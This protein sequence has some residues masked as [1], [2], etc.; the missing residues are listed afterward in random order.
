[1]R[2]IRSIAILA[3]LAAAAM[4]AGNCRGAEQRQAKLI[5][6]L[7]SPAAPAE[8]AIACKQLAI[9]G[10]QDA[11]PALAALLPDVQLS[12]WARIALEAIPGPAADAALR[13]ALGKVHGGLLLG[14]INSLGVRRDVKAVG[15]LIPR[16]NDADVEV[17]SA[18]AVAL[19]RIGGDVAT[20]A[21]AASLATSSAKTRAAVAEGCI[22]CAERSLAE[23]KP[24]EAVALYDAVRKADVSPQQVREAVRGLI[25]ARGAAGVPL[26][27]EQLQSADKASFALGLRVARELPGREVTDALLAEMSKAKPARQGLLIL[28]LADRGDAAALPAVLQMA[29]S[30]P[31]Q[32]RSVAIRVLRRLGNATCVPVLLDA[33]LDANEDVSQTAMT[34]LADM[35]GA[36]VDNDL[37]SRLLQAEGKM[38][39]ILIELAGRRPIATA[40]PTLLKA[41]GE[42]DGQVRAAALAALGATIEFRDLPLLIARVANP[43]DA[44]DDAAAA[45]A[46]GAACQRMPDREACAAKLVAAMSGAAAP[47]KCRLLEIL[48]SVGGAGA[49]QAVTAA[50][51]DADPEIQDTASRMLG[52]WM[53]VDAAP[54]LLDLAKN[55]ADEKYRIRALRGYIRLV[56]QFVMPDAERAAMCRN[57]LATA[58]RIAEKKLVLEVMGRYPSA[59]MLS[60]ALEATKTVALKNEAVAVAL[61]IA[62]KTGGH[63]AQLQKIL[64]E[65]GHGLV[66]IEIVKADYGAGAN[67]KDVTTI[68]R[69]HVHDFPVIVL[70]SPSYNATFG[71]DPAPGLVKQL[72]VQYRMAGKPGEVTFAENAT[73]Q[74]PR[75]K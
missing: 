56:R 3:V 43:Q 72:K 53:D 74:L 16:L 62:G 7:K 57:A 70:P 60:L 64:G 34:V 37:A 1:M 58:G 39:L 11:V 68:L 22:L 14:V 46:L 44:D 29:K 17:A 65:M 12:S 13:E 59:E 48:S 26:L 27:V 71:G 8:K 41:A 40:V 2:N 6:L 31:E 61:L 47:V 4:V 25:L 33:A 69:K 30:G 24:A 67:V 63:S 20:K 23:G 10:T 18:A 19:G 50:V 9:C 66:K 15:Q 52:A 45:K 55:A 28:A 5:E 73:I 49:L 32:A 51:K 21:L 36:D 75:P 42:A 54:V 38:R 35:P